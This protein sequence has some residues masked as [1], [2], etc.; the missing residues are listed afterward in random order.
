MIESGYAETLKDKKDVMI[1]ECE[2]S[3]FVQAYI[4]YRFADSY[5]IN[6]VTFMITHQILL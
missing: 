3:S 4:K 6:S 1:Q 5:G 2:S